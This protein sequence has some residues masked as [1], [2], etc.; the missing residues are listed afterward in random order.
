MSDVDLCPA[1]CCAHQDG[2]VL[3][4]I[5]TGAALW[6]RTCPECEASE[7]PTPSVDVSNAWPPCRCE[8]CATQR[9]REE[10]LLSEELK[11][12]GASP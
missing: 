1:C 10:A 12:W 4:E 6:V 2:A 8:R 9:R 11:R 5:P 7:P 3:P